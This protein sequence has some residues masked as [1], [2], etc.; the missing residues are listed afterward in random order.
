MWQ[1]K[2]TKMTTKKCV[3]CKTEMPVEIYRSRCM[4]CEQEIRDWLGVE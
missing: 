1:R 3:T 2:K 4:H